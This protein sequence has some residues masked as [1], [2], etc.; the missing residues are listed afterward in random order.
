MIP[1]LFNDNK[2][3]SIQPLEPSIS[4]TL[5]QLAYSAITK[6]GTLSCAE[7]GILGAIAGV[8]GT[9]QATEVIKEILE[10]GDSL[11]GKLVIYDALSAT[12]RTIKLP[13]D[14]Y[15]KYCGG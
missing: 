11:A 4:V 14:P 13:K 10:I 5:N 12:S 8:V 3:R 7:A 6:R 2:A 9:M 1:Y 15:C